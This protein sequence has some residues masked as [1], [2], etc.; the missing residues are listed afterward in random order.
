MINTKDDVRLWCYEITPVTTERTG[1]NLPISL[2]TFNLRFVRW[3]FTTNL[4]S[5][6]AEFSEV[7]DELDDIFSKSVIC[8]FKPARS[9]FAMTPF[10]HGHASRFVSDDITS[11]IGLSKNLNE[12][13]SN[14]TSLSENL[15]PRERLIPN[16]LSS[17][18]YPDRYDCI[19]QSLGR[20]RNGEL[21]TSN[22]ND[23]RHGEDYCGDNGE[24]YIT[25]NPISSDH[26][27]LYTIVHDQ[28]DEIN[29]LRN[30]INVLRKIIT[31]QGVEYP[32]FYVEEIIPT[33]S[34]EDYKSIAENELVAACPVTDIPLGN[35]AE[36]PPESVIEDEE[37]IMK[38]YLTEDD[39][40]E[41]RSISDLDWMENQKEADCFSFASGHHSVVKGNP[42]PQE[43]HQQQNNRTTPL[44]S[45]HLFKIP[46][47]LYESEVSS[48]FSVS[49]MLLMSFQSIIQIQAKYFSN[50]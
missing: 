5:K 10:F 43:Y 24:I 20:S 37:A 49:V 38:K 35:I 7:S 21:E 28:H 48:R 11:G 12:E 19:R 4:I 29:R 41:I 8:K 15:I 33:S 17:P 9:H 2:D 25:S 44:K 40:M 42:P 47:R 36:R 45:D 22:D 46:G 23:V 30:Y 34:T 6:H 3:D 32:D 18:I 16:P 26:R 50:G 13:Y 39:Q 31:D 14:L 27:E 1:T